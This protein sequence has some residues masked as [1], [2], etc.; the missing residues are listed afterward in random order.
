MKATVY[1]LVK[2]PKAYNNEVILSNGQRIFVNNSASSVEHINRAGVFIDGPGGSVAKPGDQLLFHHNICRESWNKKSRRKSI[3]LIADNIYYIPITEIYMIKRQGS[4]QWEALDP[5]VFIKPMVATV[6]KLNNGLEV[7]EDSYKEMKNLMGTVAY[8]NETLLG[9][10]VKD[11]DV[12]TF[13]HDSEHEFKLNNE[14]YYRM[15]T[16]DILTVHT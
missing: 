11:G 13:M 12:V 4:D 10:G 2:V 9:A 1:F 8:P 14:V 7:M 6:K 16:S 5:H 3:F 15:S